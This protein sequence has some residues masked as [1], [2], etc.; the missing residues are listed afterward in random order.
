[1]NKMKA[2]GLVPCCP[3]CGGG[4]FKNGD[5]T[6]W[7]GVAVM[8]C[9][10]CGYSAPFSVEAATERQRVAMEEFKPMTFTFTKLLDKGRGPK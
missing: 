10:N 2:S 3:M 5:K 9:S 8:P 1:M 4:N 7:L 6:V